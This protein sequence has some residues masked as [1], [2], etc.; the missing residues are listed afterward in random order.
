MRKKTNQLFPWHAECYERGRRDDVGLL[1]LE[2]TTEGQDWSHPWWEVGG[3]DQSPAGSKT[4]K[5]C[6]NVYLPQE[7]QT[8]KMFSFL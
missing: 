4:S 8:P 6:L 5:Y 1:C 2:T 7:T 3:K